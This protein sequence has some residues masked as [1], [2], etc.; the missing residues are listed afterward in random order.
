M[1]RPFKTPVAASPITVTGTAPSE[2][3]T[4][5]VNGIDYGIRWTS[6][7]GWALDVPLLA[8]ANTLNLVAKDIYGTTLGTLGPIS[9]NYT[10]TNAWGAVFINEWAADNDVILDPADGDKD[11]WFELYNPTASAISL[12]GW[13]LEDT[14]PTPTS[15]VIPAG[16]SIPAGGRLIVWAD[17][18]TIQNTGSGQLHVP[19]KLS[20]S[21]DSIT[22]RAP[23]TSVI[24]TVTF[25]QQVKNITQGR[26]PDGGATIDFLAASSLGGTN[27]AAV[28]PPNPSIAAMGGG[29]FQFTVT[30]TPGFSYQV[31]YKDDLTAASWTNLGTPVVA[32][33]VTVTVSDTPSP[34]T[35]RFYRAVRT[36]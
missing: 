31:Q 3:A 33:G 36:P 35:Q 2:V 4:I 25:G 6:V 28:Q 12:A 27:G 30:A 26:V 21:G 5:E 24:D 17:D 10:G 16:Y 8:G 13:I 22:L 19:F 29:V 9:A 20:A 18:E 11:D 7:T 15:Y 32:T 14:Q 34:Q 23:D 1:M